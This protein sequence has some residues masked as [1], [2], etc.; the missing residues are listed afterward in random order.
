MNNRVLVKPHVHC[1][2]YLKY[3][4]KFHYFFIFYFTIKIILFYN[5]KYPKGKSAT[6]VFRCLWFQSQGTK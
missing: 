5:K 2:V 1:Q 6:G 3:S 4:F